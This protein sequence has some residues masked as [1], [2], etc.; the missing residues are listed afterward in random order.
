M[1]HFIDT[2]SFLLGL[3]IAVGILI[4]VAGATWELGTTLTWLLINDLGLMQ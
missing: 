3:T 1:K 2:I 4:L